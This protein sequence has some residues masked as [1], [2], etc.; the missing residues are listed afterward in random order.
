MQSLQ[1][2][3]P[4]IGY[5]TFMLKI[6]VAWT[7]LTEGV[8]THECIRVVLFR[9]KTLFLGGLYLTT[10]MFCDLWF[11]FTNLINYSF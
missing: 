10:V 2:Y 8:I 6:R 5:I 1:V 9:A 3:D 4:L 11:W 7:I